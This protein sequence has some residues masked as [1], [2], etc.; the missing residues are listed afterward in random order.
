[1]EHDRDDA[2]QVW[3]R[4]EATPFNRAWLGTDSGEVSDTALESPDLHV[5]A[6]D[7]L[8][9]TFEHRHSFEA[10]G[11]IFFDGG[12]IEI[13]LP[14]GAT[15][16]DITTLMV[17]PG[18]GGTLLDEAG[19][20]LGGRRAFVAQNAAWPARDTVTL[21]FGTI[22]GPDRAHPFPDRHGLNTGDYRLGD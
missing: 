8:V 17:D 9:I 4:V 11:T 5:G 22:G 15:W 19:N 16:Q 20:P 14:S 2:N 6:T 10:D 13:S 21:D 3:S 12:V 18:Y 1:M 7:P